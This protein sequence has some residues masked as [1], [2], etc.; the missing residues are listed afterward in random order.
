[1]NGEDFE[2]GWASYAEQ[3][4][5]ARVLPQGK[6]SCDRQNT[7]LNPFSRGT[8]GEHAYFFLMGLK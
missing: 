6:S 1:M 2:K 8:P 7:P 5:I 4:T 3:L